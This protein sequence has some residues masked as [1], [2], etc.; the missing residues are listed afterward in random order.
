M[1][2]LTASLG[3]LAGA[4]SAAPM[5]STTLADFD[6]SAAQQ[7]R[8]QALID[9]GTL[10]L[11][12]VLTGPASGYRH[13]GWPVATR[14]P[15]GRTVVL[16][17]HL[18]DHSA[19]AGYP[20]NA[21]RIIW[22]DDNMATW[23]PAD[24]LDAPPPFGRNL[25]DTPTKYDY[26]GMHALS[27]AYA[28]GTTQLAVS[29]TA[30]LVAVTAQQDENDKT[31]RSRVYLSDDRGVTWREQPD[32]LAAMPAAAV[33]SG[34]NMVR[35][36]EFGL[37]VPFGQQTG[38]G[39][40]RQNYLASSTDA[41]ETWQIRTWPNSANSRSIEPALATWGP[42]HMVMIGRER[43]D[44]YG[45]DSSSGK[46]YYT[47]HVYKHTPGA[48]FSG[49]TFTTAR[50]NIAG[51]GKTPVAK[52]KSGYEAHDTADVIY[53]P[54]TG[55]IEMTQ[56]SRWGAGAE[57][58]LPSDPENPA[59][60]VNALNLWSI[61]PVDL[62]AGGTTW[63]FDG[64]LVERQ[65]IILGAV[66]LPKDN[67]DGYHPGGSIVDEAAGKQHIFIYVGVYTQYANAY[68]IS[69]PLDTYAFRA[70][71]GLPALP[72]P[73]ITGVSVSG[74]TATLTGINFTALKEVLV[75]G[76]TAAIVS[77]GI[78]EIKVTLP[79]GVTAATGDDV[80]VRTDHGITTGL[81]DLS[82][83]PP[84]VSAIDYDL[85]WPGKSVTITGVNLGGVAK[86]L[87]G[88][89]E[90]ASFVS[91]TDT[92]IV[93]TVPEGVASGDISI[94]TAAG[95]TVPLPVS[96]AYT[97]AVKPHDLAPLIATQPV[98]T[99]LHPLDLIASATGAP[100]PSFKW[101]YRRDDSGDWA[102]IG[103]SADYQGAGT[104]HLTLI[105]TAGK[106]GWQYRYAATNNT[107]DVYSNAVTLQ[108]LA[109][110]IPS[111]AGLTAASG[112]AGPDLYVADAQ[113]HV[114]R[115]ITQADGKAVVFA[116]QPGEP[117]PADGAAS[118]ARFNAPRGVAI[119][120]AGALVV[121]DTGNSSVRLVTADGAVTTLS[122]VFNHPRG[123]AAHDLNGD[124]YVADTGN[125]LIK[126]IT[127]G[128]AVSTI[129]GAGVPGFANG[130]GPAAQFRSPSG[131]AV[132]VAGNLYIADTGNH[133][134]RFIDMSTGSVSL[135]A[136]GTTAGTAD[137]TRSAARFNAPEGV[138]VDADGRV[139]VADTGNSHIRSIYSGSVFHSV[140]PPAG[141][142]NYAGFKDGLSGGVLF[143]RPASIVVA[144]DGLLYVADTGNA[145]IRRVDRGDEVATLPLEVLTGNSDPADNNNNSGGGGG[146]PGWWFAAALA[147]LLAFRA[148]SDKRR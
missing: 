132:D 128:G 4:M 52:G 9:N 27:W 43:T 130:I 82:H 65:G 131:I 46:Y 3:A 102:D 25:D 117:G 101:Q 17:R 11:Q 51:N 18:L 97:I 79:A 99:G 72:A 35:H 108:L 20:D 86:V 126:K 13:M 87:F 39:T 31:P 64:N 103:G 15:D 77:S 73:A 80:V 66:G 96:G 120:A 14:L 26:Q 84:A 105:N 5:D 89:I 41:G 57:N 121:A 88:A 110:A 98:V 119:T 116:G 134:I 85:I 75:A 124:I 104:A 54:V 135:F 142:L 1:L 63:R 95:D 50:T 129:A 136:G 139:F 7:T 30:R 143:D 62:L 93:V 56:S 8:M 70:A 81:S 125:H 44:A 90:V 140:L 114:I 53:N 47:Q 24:I 92:G 48:A 111:P 16:I 34:P 61:D 19:Y 22:S 145:A 118:A 49:V 94:Q 106:N 78:T 138:T 42:G 59:E 10:D 29:G 69:R 32:A 23:R 146:A 115:K 45:Y 36:P 71:C 55:R 141:F 40:G 83:L 109:E 76:K 67:K 37:V 112:T 60:P 123:V 28:S 6:F 133:A 127:A 58:P 2:M 21:R 147:V 91:K 107:E 68:R 12:R 74:N 148:L 122:A 137:G 100:P 33:H 113:A 144:E 38:S